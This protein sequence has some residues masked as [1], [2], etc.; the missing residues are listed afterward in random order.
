MIRKMMSIVALAAPLAA[1]AATSEITV[2]IKLDN[3]DFVVGESIGAVV[4]IV[5]ISPDE[6]SVGYAD[7]ADKFFVEVF[8]SK[9][10]SQL[11]RINDGMFVAPFLLK[12]NEGQKLATRL[13]DLYDLRHPGRYLAR[14][15]LVHRG[16]RYEGQIRAFD[17]VP[18]MRVANALQMF[19]NHEGLRREFELIDWSRNGVSHLFLTAK[20]GGTST[21]GWQTVDLGDMMKVTRPTISVMS[22]GEVVVLHRLDPD[23]FLRSEFW[24]VP[25]GLVLVRREIVQDPETAGSQR[26]RE[27]YQESGGIKPKKNPWW[28]FW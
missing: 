11:Q 4:N 22:S 3:I 12:P 16:V 8:R 15:V 28:K 24:S 1:L 20:D 5:N 6:I 26:V 17:V 18:G 21:R 2:G 7:S 13:G 14:P 10:M 19:A 25:A 27:L 9:D 23:N